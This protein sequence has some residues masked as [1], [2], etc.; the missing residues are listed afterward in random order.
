MSVWVGWII[1]LYHLP[2]WK[3]TFLIW[4][5]LGE[6][7]LSITIYQLSESEHEQSRAMLRSITSPLAHVSWLKKNSTS[8][9]VMPRGE[10]AAMSAAVQN[11]TMGSV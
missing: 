8:S 2:V 9:G 3:G 4:S 6:K 11:E 5:E 10:Q 1:S 7:M